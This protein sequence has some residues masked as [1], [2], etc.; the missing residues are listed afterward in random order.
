M[1]VS[2]IQEATI[3]AKTEEEKKEA[4]SRLKMLYVPIPDEIETA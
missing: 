2:N 4:A 3:M 1:N